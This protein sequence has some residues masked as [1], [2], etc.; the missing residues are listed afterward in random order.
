MGRGVALVCDKG[1]R[2]FVHWLA[3]EHDTAGVHLRVTRHP[4]EELR[5]LQRR[6][7][8]LLVERQIAG[9]WTGAEQFNQTRA[10]LWRRLVGDPTAAEAPRKALGELPDLAFPHPE[11]LGHFRERAP[12][13]KGRK[14]AH[15]G[16]MLPAILLE[17]ELH[18]VVFEVVREINVDVRQFIQRHAFLVQEPPKIEAEANRANATDAE[19]VANQAV[20]RA[21]ARD[22][23]DAA[24]PA[25]LEEIPGDEEVVLVAHISD[26]A[27]LFLDLRPHLRQ[28]HFRSRVRNDS[29]ARVTPSQAGAHEMSKKLFRRRAVRCFERGELRFPKR[30]RKV[31]ALRNFARRAEP[32]RMRRASRRHLGR[33]AKVI[34]SAA[35][36]PGMLVFQQRQCA[37]ALENVVS[38]PVFERG[39]VNRRTGD[40]GETAH[41]AVAHP[42]LCP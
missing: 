41:P 4:V 35:P 2:Q 32:L 23:L 11:H 38:A 33:G 19:A 42:S 27:Q 17:N 37:N 5:H 31:T 6:L 18:H 26:D 30:E 22:P 28:W 29:L 9:F 7:V 15:D 3:R 20:R 21:A 16:A 40:N 34:P 10:A 1:R 8:G 14:S 36:L 13:L 24:P 39:V 25:I 12:R